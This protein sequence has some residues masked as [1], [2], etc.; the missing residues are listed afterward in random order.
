MSSSSIESITSASADLNRQ[1]EPAVLVDHIEELEASPISG[2]LELEVSRPDVV[3]VFSTQQV[4]FASR[5]TLSLAPATEGEL[6][7]LHPPD[8]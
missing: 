5:R 8:R 2:L 7:P 1:A 6:Q 4:L 3:A